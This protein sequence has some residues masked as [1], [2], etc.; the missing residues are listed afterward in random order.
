MERIAAFSARI[1]DLIQH[2]T[3]EQAFVLVGGIWATVTIIT[4]ISNWSWGRLRWSRLSEQIFRL[5]KWSL[6]RV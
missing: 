2:L 1:V 4:V 5:D 3:L 6:C